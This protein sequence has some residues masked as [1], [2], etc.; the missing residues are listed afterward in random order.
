MEEVKKVKVGSLEVNQVAKVETTPQVEAIQRDCLKQ[1]PA[2]YQNQTGLK[3]LGE[4][5]R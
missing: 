4:E 5:H 1:L 2:L 3:H